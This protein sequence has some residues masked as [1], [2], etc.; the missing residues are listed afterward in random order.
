MN[1]PIGLFYRLDRRT[2]WALA[3]AMISVAQSGTERSALSAASKRSNR[4]STARVPAVRARVNAS[5][6]VRSFDRLWLARKNDR[7]ELQQPGCLLF[8]L[9][10]FGTSDFAKLNFKT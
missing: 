4:I 9:L 3:A 8:R 6:E 2:Y 10:F 5:R 1:N 7:L